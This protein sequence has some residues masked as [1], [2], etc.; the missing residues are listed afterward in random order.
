MGK[1]MTIENQTPPDPDDALRQAILEQLL[2]EAAFEGWTRETL[3]AAAKNANL[4]EGSMAEGIVD[5]LFPH[6]I[7]DALAFWSEAEDRAMV[8]AFEALNPRPHGV[9][10]KITW[11]IRQR[12]EQLDWNREAARRAGSTLALPHHGKRGAELVWQT[13]DTMWRAIG[14]T[15]TD[16]NFYTKRASLSA[17]Y[18]ATL[19][20]WFQDAGD[21]ASD[22]PYAGTWEFLDARIENLMQFEKLKARVQKTSPDLTRLVG[23]LGRMR[24]GSGK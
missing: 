3:M 8:E 4:P 9:T 7:G 5:R 23:F 21:A 2:S 14:D 1:V 19:T 16:F 18:P 13:A 15:S 11:L 24:Y 6:G 20:H 10:K 12:I 22:E 17:I